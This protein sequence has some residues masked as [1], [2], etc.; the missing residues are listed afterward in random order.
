MVTQERLKEL[1]YYNEF[2]GLFIRLVK[3]SNKTKIREVVGYENIN[4]Y[5]IISI[6]G[7]EY[8][9][10]RLAWL[11]IT[12][13]FP[14]KGI[15]HRNTIKHHNWFSNLRKCD[16]IQNQQNRR[17]AQSNNLL[18]LLGVSYDNRFN[19]FYSRIKVNNKQQFVGYFPTAELAHE[20]YVTAKR[21][22]HEFNTL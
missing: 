18:R 9:A 14:E 1:F 19:K 12:G 16:D 2:T 11:Y 7:K 10:H 4:G 6:N 5:I 15:D 17:T 8:Y 13:E 22:L 21:N 3:T 20:A